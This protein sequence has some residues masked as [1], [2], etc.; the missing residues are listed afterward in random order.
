M[1]PN[2]SKE[3]SLELYFANIQQNI[4]YNAQFI[5]EKEYTRGTKIALRI[6][7][8][9]QNNGFVEKSNKG[10][11]ELLY[12]LNKDSQ[13][14]FSITGF[15]STFDKGKEIKIEVQIFEI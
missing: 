6:T 2:F 11:I 4:L 7:G 9:E 5:L 13:E 15:A 12:K 1:Y 8:Q 3:G 10:I 14:L